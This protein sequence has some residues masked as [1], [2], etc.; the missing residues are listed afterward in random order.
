MINANQDDYRTAVAANLINHSSSISDINSTLN[1]TSAV[2]GSSGVLEVQ[3]SH[4]TELGTHASQISDLDSDLNNMTGA[5]RGS[6]YVF[7]FQRKVSNG[8]VYWSYWNNVIWSSWA[9]LGG[10]HVVGS[11]HWTYGPGARVDVFVIGSADNAGYHKWL[12]TSN[13]VWN[14]TGTTWTTMG[15]DFS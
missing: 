1:D 8:H 4:T 14:P 6:P 12:N 9:D 11:L 7:A 13:F 15:G 2:N 10:A 3:V 5:I